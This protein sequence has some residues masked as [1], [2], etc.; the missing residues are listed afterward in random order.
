[1]GGLR[2]ES[3]YLAIKYMNETENYP[4]EKLC[5]IVHIARSAYYKW[6]KRKPSKSQKNNEQV[7]TWIKQLYCCLADYLRKYQSH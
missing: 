1:M 6:L 2:Q 7:V 5:K 4:I 3:E